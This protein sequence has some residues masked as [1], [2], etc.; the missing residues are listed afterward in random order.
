MIFRRPAHDNK[1]PIEPNLQIWAKMMTLVEDLEAV[2]F[3]SDPRDIER[4]KT[5]VI[6]GA[7]LVVQWI[8]IHLP[9]RRCGFDLWAR[10]MPWRRKWQPTTV[11]WKI[12]LTVESGRLQSIGSQKNSA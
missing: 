10:K 5:E 11:S 12:P 4:S 8:R 2:F 3:K 7:S 1:Q 9:S 6:H